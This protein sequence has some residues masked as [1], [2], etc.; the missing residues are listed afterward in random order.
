MPNLMSSR[1]ATELTLTPE[2]TDLNIKVAGGKTSA[3]RGFVRNFPFS[4]AVKST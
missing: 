2:A 1:L 3:T 4:F